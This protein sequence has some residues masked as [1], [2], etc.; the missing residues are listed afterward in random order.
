MYDHAVHQKLQQFL[1]SKNRSEKR[2]SEIQCS[3]LADMLQMSEEVL[4][5][6]NLNKLSY[7]SLSKT[8]CDYL[9]SALKSN[10]SHLRY[11]HLG[12]N[13]LKDS[14]V[15]LLCGFLKSPDC[16]LETLG[17]NNC[18]LSKTSCDY[19]ASALK[20]N[21]SH[22][23]ELDLGGNKLNDSGVKLLCGFLKSPDCKLETLR[24]YY[25]RLSKTSCDYLVSA[26]K[27]NPS[28]LRYLDLDMNYLKDSDM[29]Q[30][31]GGH[32]G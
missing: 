23:K 8:S 1:K 20:S 10:S 3:A 13:K 30:L 24:L 7:C 4:D 15:K 22:L 2:L 9:V 29:K 27:S 11:L 26:L 28:H 5:E 18:R 12:G 16:K 14:G 17:L 25:C 6:L 31:C 32:L 21:S 19:L